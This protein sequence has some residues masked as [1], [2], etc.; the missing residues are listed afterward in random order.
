MYQQSLGQWASSLDALWIPAQFNL[1]SACIRGCRLAL[2]VGLCE[3]LL[4]SLRNPAG[5]ILVPVPIEAAG[6]GML[7]NLGVEY[8]I[9]FQPLPLPTTL[10]A[11]LG[12]T[13]ADVVSA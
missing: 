13:P 8:A 12:G 6:L 11:S 9:F 3:R 10:A 2:C 5:T 7:L 4:K 1:G